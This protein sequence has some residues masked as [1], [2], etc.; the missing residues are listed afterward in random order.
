MHLSLS[1]AFIVSHKFWV[2]VSSFSFVS[3]HIS[4]SFLI[5]SM[6][7][8]LFRSV[9]FRLHMFEFLII[10]FLLL[11]SNLT[12]LWSEKMT[13]MIS[14]FLNLPRLDVWPRMWSI[15]EKVRVHLRKRW[16]W[17]FWGE[18]SYRYQLGLAGPLW[19]LKFVFPC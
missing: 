18:M 19:H 12:A 8:W 4:V 3:M 13:G 9:L 11:R 6:I 15:L 7:C 2:V 17:L 1:T 14:I 16:S 5:S 10:F